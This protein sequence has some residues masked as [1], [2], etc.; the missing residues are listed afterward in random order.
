MNLIL[1]GFKK[2]GKTYYGIKVARRMHMQFID[3]DNVIEEQYCKTYHET[4]LSRDIMKRHGEAFFRELETKALATLSHIKNAVIA[5]GGGSVLLP[6]NVNFLEQ[7]GS[8]VYLKAPKEV[9]KKRIF[10]GDLPAYFDQQ[11][12]V[13]SFEKMYE[14]RKPI[15]ESIP[16]F[17]ID[18]ENKREDQI[19]T[20]LCEYMDS[21]RASYGE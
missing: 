2:C 18:T 9:L 4:L 11:H 20:M 15:Y 7:I 6:Q 17:C 12:P 1:F 19:L 21:V 5:V 10:T 14:E 16:A 8:L 13:A 3:I